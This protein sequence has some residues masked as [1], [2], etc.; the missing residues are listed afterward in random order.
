MRDKN[1]SNRILLVLRIFI[2]EKHF[3][4]AT[5]IIEWKHVKDYKV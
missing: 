5:A 3:V 1:E 2:G 4:L